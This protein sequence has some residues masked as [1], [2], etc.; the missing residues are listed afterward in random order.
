[1]PRIDDILD[2]LGG[3]RYFSYYHLWETWEKHQ[4]ILEEMLSR[5][6]AAG[7]KVKRNK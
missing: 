5:I 1:M 2:Q 7:L 4:R 3:A 6:R